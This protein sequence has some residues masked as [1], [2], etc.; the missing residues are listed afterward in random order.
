ME[1]RVLSNTKITL[2]YIQAGGT[3]KEDLSQVRAVLKTIVLEKSKLPYRTF[4]RYN[5]NN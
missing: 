5:I 4:H 1:E 3:P 2:M